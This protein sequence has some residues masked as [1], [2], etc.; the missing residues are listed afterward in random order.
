MT[1]AKVRRRFLRKLSERVKS[2]L[3]LDLGCGM[4][5]TDLALTKVFKEVFIVS[6]DFSIEALRIAKRRSKKEDVSLNMVLC[7]ACN[8][9]FKKDIFDVAFSEEV[10]EH[11]SRAHILLS[12]VQEVLKVSSSFIVSVPNKMSPFYLAW[13]K[14]L[15]FKRQWIYGEEHPYTPWGLTK[16]LGHHNFACKDRFYF[17]MP[18][19]LRFFDFYKNPTCVRVGV[20][21]IKKE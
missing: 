21:C 16:L 10:L 18:R 13:R 8:L 14:F 3:I 7:D 12:E 9:P 15:A 1:T 5:Q 2:G 6:V 20:V 19:L 17:E 11:I 4:A